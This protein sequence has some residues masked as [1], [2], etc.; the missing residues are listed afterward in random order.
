M[1]RNSREQS[2][3]AIGEDA[4]TDPAAAQSFQMDARYFRNFLPKYLLFG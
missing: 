1:P 2:L 3:V 4:R